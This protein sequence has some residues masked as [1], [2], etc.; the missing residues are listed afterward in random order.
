ML[1]HGLTS[2]V[3]LRNISQLICL[4]SLCRVHDNKTI[5]PHLLPEYLCVIALWRVDTLSPTTTI[6]DTVHPWQYIV[7][8]CRSFTYITGNRGAAGG[9]KPA[10][11]E[12]R[13]YVGVF[14]V[15]AL[16]FACMYQVYVMLLEGRDPR[17]ETV[18]Q[19]RHHILSGG[20]RSFRRY[21]HIYLT[22]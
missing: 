14:F 19:G 7:S 11:A 3:R 2:S 21:H 13:L 9:R 20:Q 22:Y 5:L 8:R 1:G 6:D 17:R 12:P 10:G 4:R 15:H 18:A 16:V